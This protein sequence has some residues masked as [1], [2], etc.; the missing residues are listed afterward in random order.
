MP[1]HVDVPLSEPFEGSIELCV[2]FS[3]PA[4]VEVRTPVAIL[5]V[6][7]ENDDAEELID[8]FTVATVILAVATETLRN[9]RGAKTEGVTPE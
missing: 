5:E 6:V 3:L 2:P 8:D 1:A 4:I 7:F 9:N